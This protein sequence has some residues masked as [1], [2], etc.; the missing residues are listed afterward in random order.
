MS[1]GDDLEAVDAVIELINMVS[2]I[3]HI[4]SRLVFKKPAISA[5]SARKSKV[6][7]VALSVVK[8]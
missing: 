6:A 7:K 2:I 1:C 3:A 8:I 5:S 4:D